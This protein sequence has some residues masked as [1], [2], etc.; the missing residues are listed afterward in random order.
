[1]VIDEMRQPE[2]VLLRVGVDTGESL[3]IL[4]MIV[5]FYS[6]QHKNYLKSNISN[7]TSISVIHFQV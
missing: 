1:M 3:F 2:L 4:S 5:I 7:F 6:K